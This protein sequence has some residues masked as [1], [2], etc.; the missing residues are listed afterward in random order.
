MIG[1]DTN[2]L[3]RFLT[4][5][6]EVQFKAVS[7]LFNSGN[8]DF[9]ISFPVLVELVWVLEKHYG[10]SKKTLLFIL[11]E[12]GDTKNIHFPDQNVFVKAIYNFEN[13]SADFSDCLIGVLNKKIA[14]NT[15]FTFDKQASKLA[16]F[17]LLK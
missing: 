3:V 7:E 1:L 4:K 17:T 16:Q 6:D 15:T 8:S 11:K 10:Y 5:D 13:S 12:L 9:L 2:I 14:V